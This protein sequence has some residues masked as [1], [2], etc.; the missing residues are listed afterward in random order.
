LDETLFKILKKIY[1]KKQYVKDEKGYQIRIETG[2]EFD[3]DTKTTQYSTANLTQ[4]ELS[5]LQKNGYPFNQIIHATHDDTIKK[6]KEIIKH[7]NVSLEN[8]TAA[9]ISGF[10]SYPRGRQ[11]IISYLFASAVPVHSF[12]NRHNQA[13]CEICAVNKE[14][15][16]EAGNEIF[17]NYWGYSWNEIRNDFYLDLDEF[18]QLPPRLPTQEDL[19]I[20]WSVIDLIGNAPA[21]ETVGKLEQRIS[22]A[23]L[24][25]NCEKYRLRG[26]LIALS[27]LGVMPNRFVK[28][29]YDGFTDFETQCEISRKAPGNPRSDV[30]LPLSGWRGEYGICKERLNEV[31]G[32]F[33]TE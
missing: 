25:P 28:P 13:V 17:R 31:F 29:L 20:F 16:L 8:L 22:K 10:Y 24:I 6:L 2:D 1:Y 21:D 33:R 23:K 19:R 27:E 26:Q 18:S 11:P 7:P 14:F 30:V 4:A 3:C 32:A 5:Y 9:Y 12:V 15:W